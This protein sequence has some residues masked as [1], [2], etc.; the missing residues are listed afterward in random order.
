M[1][2][3][4]QEFVTAELRGHAHT[5]QT[6][7]AAWN[8]SLDNVYRQVQMALLYGIVEDQVHRPATTD[9]ILSLIEAQKE[10]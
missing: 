9:D 2:T 4:Y 5:S 3:P 6:T 10:K 7:R 8:A 1:L